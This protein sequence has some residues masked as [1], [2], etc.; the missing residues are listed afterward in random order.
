MDEHY[1]YGCWGH[2]PAILFRMCFDLHHKHDSRED[3]E[4]SKVIILLNDLHFL[5]MSSIFWHILAYLFA[6]LAKPLAYY[7][8][9]P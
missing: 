5:L 9:F 1:H 2:I 6:Y 8:R 7:G 4:Y 3:N